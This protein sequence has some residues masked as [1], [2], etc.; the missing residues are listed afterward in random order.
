[1]GGSD[2][3]SHQAAGALRTLVAARDAGERASLDGGHVGEN[4][5]ATGHKVISVQAALLY[6][7]GLQMR[8]SI[9]QT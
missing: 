1:M 3:V 7:G 5:L 4:D 8:K 9:L 6:I 2:N